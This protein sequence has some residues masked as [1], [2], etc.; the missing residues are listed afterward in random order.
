MREAG[1]SEPLCLEGSVCPDTEDSATR[2][3]HGTS[4]IHGVP[5]RQK[6]NDRAQRGQRVASHQGPQTRPNNGGW[7]ESHKSKREH[8]AS[9]FPELGCARVCVCV[10]Q[11]WEGG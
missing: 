11:S 7:E 9:M 10:L 3:S 1:G 2:R 8:V 5:G 4:Q 6:G